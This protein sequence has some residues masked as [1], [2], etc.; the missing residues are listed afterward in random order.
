MNTQKHMGIVTKG[1]DKGDTS[2]VGGERV[3]KTDLRIEAYGTVDELNA[4]IGAAISFV[5]NAETVSILNKV[6]NHLFT[7]GAEIAALTERETAIEVP[8]ITSKHLIMLE[9]E[10]TKTEQNLPQQTGFI[11]P[12]G[13]KGAA[14]LHLARTICRRAERRTVECAQK[15]PVNPETIRY[16]N[17][18]SDLLF[19]YARRENPGDEPVKYE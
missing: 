9:E 8:R 18:L 4:S 10:I 1:G 17:R 7:I 3:R 11:L 12:K 14:F 15:H 13:T 19:I 6:Q 2:L 16:L 5:K